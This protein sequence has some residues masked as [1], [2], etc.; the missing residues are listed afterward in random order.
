[1]V[2][3]MTTMLAVLLWTQRQWTTGHSPSW[4]ISQMVDFC[5]KRIHLNGVVQN[6]LA[7]QFERRIGMRYL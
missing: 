3:M 1:M 7:N 4:W 6:D 5:L 2:M